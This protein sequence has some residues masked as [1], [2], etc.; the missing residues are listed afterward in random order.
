M[1]RIIVDIDSSCV[2]VYEI[3]ESK[4]QLLL[5]R[6]FSFKQ[7]FRLD[8][9][10]HFN[11]EE[12]LVRFLERVNANY[13]AG[14]IE[15][16]ARGIFQELNES[17]LSDLKDQLRK[18]ARTTLKVL[19]PEEE[20]KLLEQAL[21]G[22]ADLGVSVLVLGIGQNSLELV[23][24][25]NRQP[26]GRY[27]LNIGIRPVM[28]K[29]ELEG[30]LDPVLIE[31][32]KREIAANLPHLDHEIGAAIYGGGELAFMSK[33]HYDLVSNDLFIDPLHPSKISKF[34]YKK[35]NEDVFYRR[36]MT[37]MVA[38]FPENEELAEEARAREVIAEAIFD[39]YG[40][41]NIIPSDANLIDSLI[42]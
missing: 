22:R 3:L 11:D 20:D 1:S 19:A 15:A 42:G 37:E 8:R 13:L 29:Y 25:K 4:A 21:I 28:S 14:E 30:Q 35:G 5:T 27:N 9:G 38:E 31:R 23:I 33:L 36:N 26:I 40:V 39:H 2:K 10:I 12:A 6:S 32:A 7:N 24:A 18:R 17:Q 41:E 16:Y 34:S